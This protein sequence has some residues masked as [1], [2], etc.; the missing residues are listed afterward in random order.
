MLARH[1]PTLR[2][3]YQRKRDV[4]VARSSDASA[5]SSRGPRREAAS[6]CGRSSRG[7]LTSDALLPIARASAA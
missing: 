2:A 4:M 3:H 7:T 1:L 5:A 6:S